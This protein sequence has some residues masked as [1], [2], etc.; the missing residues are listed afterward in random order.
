MVVTSQL[1]FH[2]GLLNDVDD[3]LGYYAEADASLPSKFL[4]ELD[5]VF[6]FMR[7]YPMGA[8]SFHAVYRRVALRHFPYLVCYRVVPSNSTI[9]VLAIVSAQRDPRWVRVL[10]TNRTL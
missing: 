8:P 1:S 4:D 2:P 9:R 3:I 5:A 10:L 7:R 6:S